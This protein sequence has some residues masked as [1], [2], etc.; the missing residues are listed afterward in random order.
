MFSLINFQNHAFERC[1]R[2]YYFPLSSYR[3]ADFC[4]DRLRFGNFFVGFVVATKP[5]ES[6]IAV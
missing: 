2:C 3:D 5:V 1:A 4:I 6:Q